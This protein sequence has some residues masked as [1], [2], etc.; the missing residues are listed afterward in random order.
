MM[1]LVIRVLL[2]GAFYPWVSHAEPWLGNRNAQNCAGCHAPGRKNL[3]PMDRRCTLSCQ[4]C[5]VNPNGGGMRSFYGKWNQ[6]RWL[7][8]FRTP[9][10]P[11]TRTVAPSSKQGP[12][13]TKFEQRDP[14]VGRT[15]HDKGLPL[16]ETDDVH[17]SEE[18]YDRSDHL[19]LEI[20]QSREAFLYQ[21]PEGD[22]YRQF[23]LSRADAGGDL[24]WMWRSLQSQKN[25]NAQVPDSALKWQSFLMALD[26]GVRW[27][28]IHR[29]LHFVYEARMFGAP[30]NVRTKRETLSSAGTRSLYAMVDNLPFNTYVMGGYYKPLFGTPNVDHNALSQQMF[31]QLVS[32]SSRSQALLFDAVTVGTAPNVP[33]ANFHYIKRRKT[34]GG[35]IDGDRTNGFAANLGLRFVTL[36]AAVNASYWKTSDNNKMSDEKTTVE[37][38]SFG[39]SAHF[40]HRLIS[41]LEVI[42]F[43]RDSNL[44]DYRRGG[45]ISLE[46]KYRVF[47]E[48]YATLDL[49]RANTTINL[50]PGSTQQIKIGMRM[51]HLAGLSTSLTYDIDKERS[52][53]DKKDTLKNTR[54]TSN[55][56]GQIHVY[57]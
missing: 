18:P 26:A 2:L 33:F 8:S 7:R 34:I 5:H 48:Y 10:E 47:R 37:A 46:N 38:S 44:H 36:G 22:P 1:N 30:N 35:D 43:A 54:Q 23:N 29:N 20:S 11:Q 25:S 49:A 15:I 56:T 27:R 6:E 45:V 31:S 52:E 40:F 39:L 3:S 21:I 28:P 24:R 13:K 17:V 51:F 19:E 53:G 32:G 57:F 14:E 4:G 55:I 50:L 9:L 16:V 42:S 41:G 12:G